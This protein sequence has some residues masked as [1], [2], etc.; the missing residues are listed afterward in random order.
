M[1]NEKKSGTLSLRLEPRLLERLEAVAKATSRSRGEITA[2]A[3]EALCST[4]EKDGRLDFPLQVVS[5]SAVAEYAQKEVV[6][7]RWNELVAAVS[8]RMAEEFHKRAVPLQPH[9]KAEEDPAEV[10]PFTLPFLGAVAAGEP[11][12]APR[13]ETLSVPK[14]FPKGHFIVEINGRS[15]EPKFQDGERWVIDGRDCYTP[16]SGKPCIVSDGAGS[17]LKKWNRKRGVFESINPDF[18][19]V[20]PGEE[21]QLQ[22]YPVARLD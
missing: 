9:E 11:V 12:E 19:D 20:L 8:E 2:Q 15:G 17:Y 13:N 16:K 7:N 10:I 18:P 21:A 1:S 22:G 3:L 14:S 5:A 4:F 6:E